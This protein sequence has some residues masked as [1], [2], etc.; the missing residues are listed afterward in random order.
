MRISLFSLILLWPF[1]IFGGEADVISAT[2]EYSG[3]DF[4][5]FSVTVQHDDEDWEHFAK[6]WEVLDSDGNMLGNRVLLHPH[7]NEQPFTRSQTISIPDN[8]NQVTIRAYDLI[9][10][11]GGK[12][13]TLKLKKG[14]TNEPN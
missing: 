10:K 6:A 14:N 2:V 9:H 11:F 13:L 12:E 8:V 1:S 5:R 4:Y 7:V 3:G